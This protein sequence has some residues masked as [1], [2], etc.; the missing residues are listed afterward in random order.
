[1]DKLKDK[2]V[3]IVGCGGLGG[4]VIEELSRIGVGKL[5]LVDGDVFSRSNM[6]RQLM[7]KEETLGKSKVETYAKR[8][9]EISNC[10]V[11]VHSEFLTEDNTHLIDQADIVIDCVDNVEAR[12]LIA[13]ACKEKGKMFVHGAIDG[14]EGQV[15]LCLPEDNTFEKYYR[16]VDDTLRHDTVSYAVATVASIEA[17][18]AVKAL[19]GQQDKFK[20]KLIIIDLESVFVKIIDLAL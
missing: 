5:I 2:S 20:G 16:A 19:L 12:F 17:N 9:G 3:L 18:V 11:E 14:E 1:M 6:N 7:A 15:M 4:Y 8:L 10:Q 13:K